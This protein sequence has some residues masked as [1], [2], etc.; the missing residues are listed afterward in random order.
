MQPLHQVDNIQLPSCMYHMKSQH[1][2]VETNDPDMKT[3]IEK[4]RKIVNDLVTLTNEVK[5]LSLR[6]GHSFGESSPELVK[7]GSQG[8]TT[9]ANKLSP[10]LP[11]GITDLV[12]SAS[13]AQPAF[14]AV[15]IEEFLKLHGV[16]VAVTTQK[17][18]SLVRD[19]PD[20][21][22]AITGGLGSRLQHDVD[23]LVFSF[24]WKDDPL[25]PSLMHD[26]KLQTRVVGDANIARYLARLLA[27]QLYN[28]DNVGAAA[29]IDRWIDVSVQLCNGNSK[30]KDSVLK[31]MNSHLGKN[32]YFCDSCITL[33]DITLL[34][35]LLANNDHVKNLPKNVKKWFGNMSSCFQDAISRFNVPTTWTAQ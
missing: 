18:S 26:P 1:E 22:L 25:C 8:M 34:A 35:A 31:S 14:S 7:E 11:D 28:E 23:Q 2:I 12:I 21:Y 19:V 17:H 5:E 24:M 9:G 30:E 13:V 29:D 16:H 6:L 33:A 10:Q 4:D 32:D 3:L 15:L 27:P 20:N